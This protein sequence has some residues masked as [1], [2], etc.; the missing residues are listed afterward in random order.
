MKLVQ[1]SDIHWR[2]LRRHDEYRRAFENAFADI[3]QLGPDA[4]IITGDIVHTKTQGITPELID[5]LTWWFR[6]MA[7]I[8]DVHI[9]LG[10]HDGALTNSHRQDA[11]SPI[12]GALAHPR[13]HLYKQSGVYQ[14][15]KGINL[16]VF[17]IFDEQGWDNVKPID[18]DINIATFHGSVAGSQTDIGWVLESD[19][20]VDFFEAYDCCMLGDIHMQQFLGYREIEKIVSEDELISYPNAEIVEVFDE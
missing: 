6:A 14:I 7:D 17:S 4:I 19:L 13:L 12:I 9:T 20:T 10:N 15:Q 2:P 3:R 11:I 5:I 8:C 1:L 18:G 16:C